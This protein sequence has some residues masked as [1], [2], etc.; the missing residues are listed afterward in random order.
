[1][2]KL[3]SCLI[4]L[5]SIK[6]FAAAPANNDCSGAVTVTPGTAV[7]GTV[8]QATASTPVPAGCMTGTADDDVW[9][10]FTA[11]STNATILITGAGTKLAQ[12]GIRTQLFSGAC[13][14]LASLAC[15][16]EQ[17]TYTSLTVGTQ[18]YIR[19]Y[20][21][22]NNQ[23]GWTVS[24]D[25]AF[26]INITPTAAVQTKGGRMGEIF[27]QTI[28]SAASVLNNP[29]EITYGYD[30]YLW[31]TESKGYRAY[32][33]DPNTGHRDTVLD[34]SQ[35]STFFSAP[36]DQAFNMQ[37]NIGTNNPQGGFAGLVLHPKFMTTKP[38]VYISYV[39]TFVANNS[40][41]GTFY[42]NRLVRFTY[43]S[44]TNK[45]ESPVAICDTLPGSSD[46]NGQRIMIAPVSGT[47]YLFYSQGDMGTGQFNNLNR[48]NHAQDTMSYEGKILRF[49]LEPDGDAGTYD[50]WIP[51]DN[52]YSAIVGKQSAAWAIGIRNPQGFAYDSVNSV[53][54]S[55]THG[56]MSDDE[57]NIINRGKNYGHP[58]IIGKSSDN[59]YNGCKAAPTGAPDNALPPIVSES[60]KATAWGSNYVD[61]LF[62][63]YDP[64]PAWVTATYAVPGS[65]AVWPSEAWSGIDFYPYSQI[66]GWKNS[67]LVA[68]LKWGRMIRLKLNSTST[69]VTPTGATDTSTFFGGRN[70]FRDLAINPLNP[71][72]IFTISDNSSTTSGPRNSAALELVTLCGG[73]IVKYNFLGYTDVSGKSSI[74]NTIPVT[75]GATNTCNTANSVVIDATN[76]NMWVPITGQDGNI[77]AEIYANGNNLGTVT[78]SYWINSG[79]IRIKNGVH[80]LDRNLT[81]TPAV[82]PSSAVKIRLYFSKA[83]FDALD[84][85]PLSG[86]SAI[87]DL[88][89]LKNSDACGGT[90]NNST[91]LINPTFAEA[92]GSNGYMLQGS[93]S[94]F[95][96]FYFGIATITLPLDLVTFTGSLQR[97]KSTL[98]NW[99]TQHEV[100]TASF[101]VERSADGLSYSSIGTV[102]SRNSNTGSAYD[103]TDRNAL[104]TKSPV[105]YYRLKIMDADGS[106]KYSNVVTVYMPGATGIVNIVPN[107]VKTDAK[108]TV[109]ATQSG[110]VDWSLVDNAGKVIM[111]NTAEVKKD[112]PTDILLNMNGLSSGMY[113]LRVEG[114][115]LHVNS[116]VQKL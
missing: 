16:Q 77:L 22:G 96:S 94:S 93:I 12:S 60:A 92:F 65:N 64:T 100:N 26:T 28:L 30:G 10:K 23:T 86:V 25:G 70:R 53:L 68:G 7:T 106:F 33:I 11:V 21:A 34:I 87:T 75:D 116:K 55:A 98:L 3:L 115:G 80:L 74:P 114:A 112:A 84:L 101:I 107:P 36:A 72:E 50:K 32:R 81:I 6:S 58:Y 63:G 18:Y 35:G 52:P 9:Y 20:S 91:T 19:I 90:V 17:L 13:A 69:A 2:K 102:T 110:S 49:N 54:F 43:N 59:N 79:A 48:T 111:K 113:F 38:Y 78:A 85:D 42:T 104:Q 83:E 73:C 109:I 56:P 67:L 29:W 57:I 4:I 82:Q 76:N 24:G 103:F 88:K 40:P 46:H 8:F 62:S 71:R 15:G 61:P 5:A 89:I 51:N 95:S 45:L 97:D 31:V 105:L 39:H 37:F 66:P 27:N 14:S 1:M 47:D 41:N 44:T 99:K 108:V